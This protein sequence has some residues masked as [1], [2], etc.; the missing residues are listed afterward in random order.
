MKIA[1]ILATALA[2]LAIPLSGQAA[3]ATHQ[4]ANVMAFDEPA[5][6]SLSALV[7]PQYGSATLTRNNNGINFT[8]HTTGLPA[9]DAVTIWWVVFDA[10]NTFPIDV[11]VADGHVIGGNGVGNFGGYLREGATP[12]PAGCFIP[13][14]SLD[15]PCNGLSTDPAVGDSRTANVW[16]LVRVHGPARPGDIPAQIHTSELPQCAPTVCFQV[17][18]AFFPGV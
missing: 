7:Q 18:G 5:F 11:S 17:Q 13:G 9:G 4:T 14:G 15:F 2:A 12:N 16:L 8:L 6:P 10:S 1:L 3:P